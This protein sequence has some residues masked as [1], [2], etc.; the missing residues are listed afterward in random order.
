MPSGPISDKDIPQIKTVIVRALNEI[1]GSIKASGQKVDYETIKSGILGFQKWIKQQGCVS[2]ASSRY[3]IES[4]EKY[5][6]QIFVTY[7]GTLA[8]D[9]NFKMSGS[10]KNPYRLLLFVSKVDLFAMA[11]LVENKSL[12]GV[13]VPKGWPKNPWS[14]WTERP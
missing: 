7:P 4:T 3:D 6:T 10:N 13:P 5:P 8:F 14:F 2:Q 12:A 1:N 9:I 11:S